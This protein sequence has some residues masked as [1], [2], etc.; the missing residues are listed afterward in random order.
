MSGSTRRFV[1]F[2]LPLLRLAHPPSLP[3]PE[4][5]RHE[6]ELQ[7]LKKKWEAIVAKSLLSSSPPTTTSMPR[8]SSPDMKRSSHAS[9]SS[10][11]SLSTTSPHTSPTPR[12]HAPLHTLDLSLLSS[13][14][15]PTSA[16]DGAGTPEIELPES[17]QAATKWMGGMFGKVLDA[18]GAVEEAMSPAHE[19]GEEERGLGSLAEE[20]EPE[21]EGV[22]GSPKGAGGSE[23]SKSSREE[24]R[25]SKASSASIDSSSSFGFGFL[26]GGGESSA[27]T[28]TSTEHDD[29]GATPTPSSPAALPTSEPL[30][31]P[32]L[33][34]RRHA[35]TS[36]PPP[37]F[38]PR[39]NSS[40]ARSRSTFDV[41]SGVTSGGWS[42]L[43]KRWTA[44]TESETFKNG[45]KTT[46]GLLDTF[47]QG[48]ATALGPLDPPPLSP[49]QDDEFGAREPNPS[50]D[51]RAEGEVK[52]PKQGDDWDWSAF[53]DGDDPTAS[54]TSG[55]QQPKIGGYRRPS[56]TPKHTT[57]S[58]LAKSPKSPN[59][60][61]GK[62]LASAPSPSAQAK[63]LSG[64]SERKVPA[65]SAEKAAPAPA[66]REQQ[67]Q[68]D[69]KPALPDKADG[70]V[71]DSWATW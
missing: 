35:L 37:S 66:P 3:Q 28:S 49:I 65:A 47:E 69:P 17:V 22:E 13:T 21:E 61:T 23:A 45:R 60:A 46:Y 40:H 38:L 70:Y 8:L 68:E 27:R 2:L 11:S 71:S 64:S 9:A 36:P 55:Q 52:T 7:S 5:K 16:H 18:V 14:F 42:S 53:L 32:D 26:G 57:S 43:G 48:L 41:L 12:P 54:T 50:D 4:L 44:V 30:C 62:V 20:E 58:T 10:T 31:S 33:T 34:Q 67:E 56:L 29:Q 24:R 19:R 1:A 59:S 39:S 15:D 63:R 25:A 51:R 6:S